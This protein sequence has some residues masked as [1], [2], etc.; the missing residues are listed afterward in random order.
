MFNTS[1]RPETDNYAEGT[2]VNA[3]SK[4]Y[5]VE[6]TKGSSIDL[7]NNWW[8]RAQAP[9]MKQIGLFTRLRM[10]K[11]LHGIWLPTEILHKPDA[12]EVFF[13]T[14]AEQIRAGKVTSVPVQYL[15]EAG[16]SL[17][18]KKGEQ[19]V[20]IENIPSELLPQAFRP[21]PTLTMSHSYHGVTGANDAGHQSQS[22]IGAE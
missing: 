9:A 5:I 8:T 4:A 17:V 10:E 19:F 22:A 18:A 3:I 20:Q 12:L 7:I 21:K 14:Y 6:T 16:P 1:S 15:G 13:L 2:V 11:A